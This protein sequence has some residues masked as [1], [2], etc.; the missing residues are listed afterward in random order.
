MDTYRKSHDI[1]RVKPTHLKDFINWFSVCHFHD[2]KPL[3]LNPEGY[4]ELIFQVDGDFFQTTPEGLWKT[5]PR[6]FIGGLHNKSYTIKPENKSSFLIS[7]NFKPNCARFFIPEKLHYFKN[8]VIPLDEVFKPSKL[9]KIKRLDGFDSVGKKIELIEA[10]LL[11]IMTDRIFSPVDNAL[12]SIIYANGF[13]DIGSLAESS[14]LS[15][16]QLRKRFNE[17][18]GMSPKEYS[19]VLRVNYA[20]QLMKNN[21]GLKLT[22]ITYDLGY[23]DQSH[24]IKDFKSVTGRS[25]KKYLL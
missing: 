4:F 17:E 1:L 24:F 22:Q 18:V 25:P 6:H 9:E 14:C 12:N 10:F 20:S 23:F 2:I 11:K 8:Q 21:P 5:R 15:P 3:R 7:V 13:I 16:S 19:K